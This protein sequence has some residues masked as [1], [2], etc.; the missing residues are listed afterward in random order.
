MKNLQELQGNYELEIDRI[1]ETIKK[2][3]AKNVL[4]QF[5]DMF[6]PYATQIAEK[7]EK[8]S[9]ASCLIWLNTC[10]GACDIPKVEGI[11]PKID[12]IVQ[13]G[14]SKWQNT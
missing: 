12:L 6:K 9:K 13:F 8:Q 7:I 2:Q 1:V 11:K 10:F 5:P 14:H 4:L 3:G